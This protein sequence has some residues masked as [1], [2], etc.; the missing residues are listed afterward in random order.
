MTASM[1]RAACEQIIDEIQTCVTQMLGEYL[2]NKGKIRNSCQLQ[3]DSCFL[4][5]YENISS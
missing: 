4:T 2:K 1:K 3:S 5:S